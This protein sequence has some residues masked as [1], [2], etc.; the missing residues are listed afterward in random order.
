MKQTLIRAALS[1]ALAA[2]LVA[3]QGQQKAANRLAEQLQLSEEQKP[4]VAAILKEQRDALQ[5][6]RQKNAGRA[7]LRDIQAN[8]QTKLKEVL[9]EEQM[10]KWEEIRAENR[11]KARK[12]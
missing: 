10:K 11:K 4:K 6:A 1:L 9:N 5:D 2:S 3:A 7:A 8:T 12:P